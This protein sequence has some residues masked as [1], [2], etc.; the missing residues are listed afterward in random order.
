MKDIR[1]LSRFSGRTFMHV[2]S[3]TA[4]FVE[5]IELIEVDRFFFYTSLKRLEMP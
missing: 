5:A 2:T 1:G 3:H 4:V